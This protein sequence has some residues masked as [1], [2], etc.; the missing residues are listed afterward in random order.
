MRQHV[1]SHG[2]NERLAGYGDRLQRGLEG[3]APALPVAFQIVRLR[4]P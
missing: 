2:A 3:G 1:L 4:K